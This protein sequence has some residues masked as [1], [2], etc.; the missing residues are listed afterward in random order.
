[1]Q[2]QLQLH[3]I[4]QHYATLITVHYANYTTTTTTTA[5]AATTT[6]T[7]TTL[8]TLHHTTL[9]ALPLHKLHYTTLQLQL[10]YTKT[11]TTTATTTRTALRHTSSKSCGWGDHCNHRNHPKKHNPNHLSVHQRIRSAIHA[12]QQLTS[13]IGFLFSK[14]PPPPCAVLLVYM[15]IYYMCKFVYL[16]IY[17]YN[18]I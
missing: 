1:M 17:I 2:M 10:H 3:Y 15:Y 4:T 5:A 12:S 11:T 7:T 8:H 6:T 9:I 16:I 14:L 13:P 18:Y